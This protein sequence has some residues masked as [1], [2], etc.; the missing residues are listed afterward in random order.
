M[1]LLFAVLLAVTAEQAKQIVPRAD[2]SDLSDEQRAVFLEVATDVFDYAGCQE[3]LAKCLAAGVS[4]PHALRMAELVKQVVREGFP[5]A[6]VV[7]VVER[8]YASFDPRQ[9]LQL[10]TD[11]CGVL[12]KGPL[13]IVEF[14]DYQ[15]P[16]CAAAVK[17]LHDLVLEQ[18]KGKVR[19]CSKHFPFPQHARARVAAL[20]AEY[21]RAH[22]KFWQLHELIFAHQEQLE[23]ADLKKYAQEA[24]LDGEQMLKEVYAG[25]FDDLVEKHIREGKAAGVESTPALFFDGRMNALP[26]RAWYLQ[27]TVDDELQW[28]KEKGWR[29]DGKRVAKGK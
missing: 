9:R 4:D 16:H 29:F 18:R 20:C 5:A 28:Q 12:G 22:G 15:C 13:A 11:N 6:A 8:Y 25:K 24:G 3:T 1:S 7:Q 2:L 14:S 21:A 19:L 17:P 26:V 23:D 10:R 27:F